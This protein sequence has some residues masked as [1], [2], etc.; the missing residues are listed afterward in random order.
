MKQD[1]DRLEMKAE[2][3]I[4]QEKVTLENKILKNQNINDLVP[5]MK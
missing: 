4:K 3:K 1:Q 2:L 5:L